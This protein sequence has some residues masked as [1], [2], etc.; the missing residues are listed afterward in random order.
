MNFDSAEDAYKTIEE[1]LNFLE[2]RGEQPL[3]SILSTGYGTG[4]SG[5]CG[6]SG[7]VLRNRDNRWTYREDQ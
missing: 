2:G 5:M 4:E 6:K 1:A 3:R 7:T